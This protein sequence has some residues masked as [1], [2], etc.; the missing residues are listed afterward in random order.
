MRRGERENKHEERRRGRKA[1]SGGERLKRKGNSIFI[2]IL[3]RTCSP[4]PSV[5][6]EPRDSY[7]CISEYAASS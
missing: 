4:D 6:T 7:Q 2:Y 5:D 3:F 1:M